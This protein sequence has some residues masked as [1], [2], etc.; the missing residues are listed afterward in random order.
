MS[1][2]RL[3]GADIARP[4]AGLAVLLVASVPALAAPSS[5][6]SQRPTQATWYSVGPGA[7][8]QDGQ[9]DDTY[10]LRIDGRAIAARYGHDSGSAGTSASSSGA[11]RDSAVGARAG[12]LP[13]G[14]TTAYDSGGRD[15]GQVAADVVVDGAHDPVAALTQQQAPASR[16][17]PP[18]AG[19]FLL[20]P[21]DVVDVFV[22]KHSD[23]SRQV[24]VRPDGRISLPLVGE[25]QV[26]G[27]TPAAVSDE[28]TALLGDYI[29]VPE[30]T[31]SV[32]QINS[33]MV[34]VLG[35]VS[36]PGPLRLDR[37]TTV[38]QA[39]ATAGGLTEFAHR[40]DIVVIRREHGRETRIPFD[41]DDLVKDKGRGAV[42]FPLHPGDIVY[43][44]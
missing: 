18:A 22:W 17:R 6:Q 30:V 39:L 29:Q 5:A 9:A 35:E 13:L 21:G 20:G 11:R 41:Y 40:G 27:R 28:V 14:P 4:L 36:S 10:R 33:F 2:G 16:A 38:I 12:R 7:Y 8:P 23:L 32:T 26:A 25:L 15:S 44:P 24:P 34:Y 31:V 42:D 1:K 43:V 37:R 19:G 3:V